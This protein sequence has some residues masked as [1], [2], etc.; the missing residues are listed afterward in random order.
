MAAHFMPHVVVPGAN[1]HHQQAGDIVRRNCGC[2]LMTQAPIP[3]GPSQEKSAMATA[4]GFPLSYSLGLAV[5]DFWLFNDLK[6]ELQGLTIVSEEDLR[7][8][9]RNSS[10][11]ASD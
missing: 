2:I 8:D 10:V 7:A 5:F 1:S 6:K 4:P 9:S 11:D 3:R